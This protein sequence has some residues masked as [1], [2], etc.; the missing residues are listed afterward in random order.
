MDSTSPQVWPTLTSVPASGSVTKTT[1]PRLSAVAVSVTACALG[2][3]AEQVAVQSSIPAGSLCTEPEPEIE[4]DS[5]S[6]A[7]T[8]DAETAVAWAMEVT[9]QVDVPSP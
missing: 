1:S 3:G 4:T 5:D 2:N 9:V 7:R 8:N 6:C